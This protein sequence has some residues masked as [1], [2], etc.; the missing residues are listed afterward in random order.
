MFEI[1]QAQPA[2]S[3]RHSNPVQPKR[4]HFGPQVTREPIFRINFGS[5]RRYS[6]VRKARG[7]FADRIRHLSKCEIKTR[8]HTASDY[9]CTA[10]VTESLG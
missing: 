5:K 7:C 1:A 9:S 4:A 2:I 6:V 10:L 3:L 8:C